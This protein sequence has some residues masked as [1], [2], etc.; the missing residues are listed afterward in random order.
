MAGST[1]KSRRPGLFVSAT[2][3]GA[4][5]RWG[6]LWVSLQRTRNPDLDEREDEDGKVS[7]N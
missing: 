1:L 6:G 4:R 3:R 7:P 5:R 2:E